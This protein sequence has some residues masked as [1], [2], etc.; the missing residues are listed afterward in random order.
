M[1][2]R[3]RSSLVT[4][5]VLCGQFFTVKFKTDEQLCQGKG[6]TD[7]KEA[8]QMRP[9]HCDL[10]RPIAPLNHKYFPMCR[11]DFP[12]AYVT[13]FVASAAAR[14]GASNGLFLLVAVAT[15][16]RHWLSVW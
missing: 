11:E 4:S 1:N 9:K 10:K 15:F 2:C 6:M 13:S 12:K 7:Q 8:W 14:T 5:N 3:Y 16:A